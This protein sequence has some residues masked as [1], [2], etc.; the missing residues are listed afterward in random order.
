MASSRRETP[1]G[2]A[3]TGWQVSGL[4]CCPGMADANPEASC[5][6]SFLSVC[7]FLVRW[8]ES[9]YTPAP[10]LA[11]AV[12]EHHCGLDSYPPGNSDFY[13]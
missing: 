8:Q 4:H 10:V 5:L 12:L 1:Q 3:Q 13:P 6:P 9:H 2:A 7:V 11:R